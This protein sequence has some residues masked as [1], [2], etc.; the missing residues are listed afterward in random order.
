MSNS[1]NEPPTGIPLS[2]L[3]ETFRNQPNLYIDQLRSTEPV[4]RD[5]EPVM[6]L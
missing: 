2:A 4:H 3:D 1:E 5:L 6:K